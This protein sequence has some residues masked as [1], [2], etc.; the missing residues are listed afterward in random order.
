MQIGDIN[1]YILSDNSS[2]IFL[3]SYD[4]D[5][6]PNGFLGRVDNCKQVFKQ[7]KISYRYKLKRIFDKFY[8]RLLLFIVP[9]KSK[10]R[11]IRSI[12]RNRSL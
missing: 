11:K 6:I 1:T 5:E 2:R 4:P 3:N 12:I 10:R 8:Y 9:I 7:F